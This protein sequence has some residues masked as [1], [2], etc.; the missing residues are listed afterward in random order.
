MVKSCMI[1][2]ST[3]SVKSF[4]YNSS[5]SNLNSHIQCVLTNNKNS[6]FVKTLPLFSGIFPKQAVVINTELQLGKMNVKE[7]IQKAIRQELEGTGEKWV[8]FSRLTGLLRRDRIYLKPEYFYNNPDFLVYRTE[9][10]N[11]FYITL[12]EF[13]SFYQNSKKHPPLKKRTSRSKKLTSKSINQSPKLKNKIEIDSPETLE[14]ALLNLLISLTKNK[15]NRLIKNQVLSNH[16]YQ[17]YHQPIRQVIKQYYP[18]EK[19]KT[20]LEKSSLFIIRESS[21]KPDQWEVAVNDS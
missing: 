2:K 21:E 12:P 13:F 17:V 11:V 14:K 16:F 9:N 3:Q 5:F 4:N 7:I 20:V 18:N 10:I 19:L 6:V 8:L 15:P 1:G